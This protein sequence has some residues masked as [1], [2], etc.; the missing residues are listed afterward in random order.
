MKRPYVAKEDKQGDICNLI[1]DL[2]E[3]DVMKCYTEVDEFFVDSSGFGQPGELA[4][5]KDQ[6][7]SKVKKGLAYAITRIGQFQVYVTVY[8]AGKKC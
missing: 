2:S 4:L 6:F 3:G 8:K 1:P 5:T 7:L